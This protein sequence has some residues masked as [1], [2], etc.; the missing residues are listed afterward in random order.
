MFVHPLRIT[1]NRIIDT[2]TRSYKTILTMQTTIKTPSNEQGDCSPISEEEAYC[3]VIDYC[4][5]GGCPRTGDCQLSLPRMCQKGI[6]FLNGY[7]RLVKLI[8]NNEQDE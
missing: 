7:M 4:H 5:C 8:K 2:N 1:P 3:Q 6:D